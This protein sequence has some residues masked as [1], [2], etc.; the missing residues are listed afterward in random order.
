MDDSINHAADQMAKEID[1][2]A[3]LYA[4]K[5]HDTNTEYAIGNKEAYELFKLKRN[6]PI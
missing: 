3:L 2:E 1:K 4:G 5:L 6:Y